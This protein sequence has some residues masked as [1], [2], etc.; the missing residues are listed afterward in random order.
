[1]RARYSLFAVLL[2]YCLVHAGSVTLL[3]ENFE[4]AYTGW[5][6]SGDWQVG[7]PSAVGPTTVPQ[8]TR[9]AATNI[10]GYYTTSSYTT[11]TSPA[12]TIPAIATQVTFSFFEWYSTMSSYDYLY[13][14]ISTN[15]GLSW[16]SLRTAVSG[17]SMI[18]TQRSYDLTAYK[19]SSVQVRFRLSPSGY[20]TSYP[21][22][23]I[24]SVS[25]VAT[26]IDTANLPHIAVAPGSIRIN[27]GDP[28]TKTL[29]ICNTGVRDTLQYSFTTA[30]PVSPSIVAWTY[31]ADRSASRTG[32]S[33]RRS[34]WDTAPRTASASGAS[35]DRNGRAGS[36]G[37]PSMRRRTE[38]RFSPASCRIRRLC[39]AS[40]RR[41]ATSG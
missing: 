18:W 30:N 4:G 33:E 23:Y 40:S 14:E 16:S 28:A 21:G 34:R 39:T 3:S 12:V 1:M 15:G 32:R 38:R 10:S 13:L 31:G 27:A 7:I 19:G 20:T 2:S 25:L 6:L 26:V 37:A 22:W 29:T 9:C 36:L 35:S 5:A 24:D 17:S 11:L 8:G 41:S